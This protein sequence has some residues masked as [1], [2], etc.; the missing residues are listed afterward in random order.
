MEGIYFLCGKAKNMVAQ[1]IKEL[2]EIMDVT[3]EEMS[4]RLS[5]SLEQ[6]RLYE[7]GESDIP[8]S[9]LYEIAAALKTDFTVLISG[10]TPRMLTHTIVRQGKGLSV[11]RYPGY[12]FE[13]LAFNFIGREMEPMLVTLSE[14]NKEVSLV[15]HTGQEFNYVLEGAIKITLGANEHELKKGDCIYF[16]PNIPHKQEAVTPSATFLTIIKE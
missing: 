3:E 1:R 14:N 11:E 8:I 16:D 7:S 2:R 13:S 9:M 6:Y 12:E 4:Q 10:E 15:S 5:V